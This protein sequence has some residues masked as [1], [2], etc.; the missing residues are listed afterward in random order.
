MWPYYYRIKYWKNLW[1]NKL[2]I[3]HDE[4]FRTVY[5]QHLYKQHFSTFHYPLKIYITI[6]YMGYD[7]R[8][9]QKI[10]LCLSLTNGFLFLKFLRHKI[11]YCNK[12]MIDSALIACTKFVLIYE[13]IMMYQWAIQ[14][15]SCSGDQICKVK[16]KP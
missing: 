2:S 13:N 4:W 7:E 8:W 10:Y 14:F 15:I 5:L 1:S 11:L 16:A 12:K 9:I 6:F 3:L